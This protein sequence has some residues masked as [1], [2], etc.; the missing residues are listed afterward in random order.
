MKRTIKTI[1][2]T[3]I[4]L[5]AVLFIANAYAEGNATLNAKTSMRETLISSAT[6][7]RVYAIDGHHTF[8]VGQDAALN[9]D[10]G[11]TNKIPASEAACF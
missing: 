8:V 3:T 1:L 9:E 7:E 6:I 2:R 10:K 11:L 4:G 5:G